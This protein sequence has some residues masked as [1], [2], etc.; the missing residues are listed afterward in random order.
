MHKIYFDDRSFIICGPGETVPENTGAGTVG[1][2]DKD[3]VLD[4]IELFK[5]GED[6]CSFILSSHDPAETYRL[7]CSAFK[8]VNAAGGLVMDNDGKFLLIKRNSVWDL[9]KGHQE[10]GEDIVATAIREVEEETGAEGLVPGRLL[11]ITD[12]C[13]YRNGIC[14][15]KHTWWYLMSCDGPLSPVPQT[16]EGITETVLVS[17]DG[18]EDLMKCTYPSILDVFAAAEGNDETFIH[19]R[20]ILNI[21]DNMQKATI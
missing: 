13:Y 16:E 7:V 5:N 6:S 9:P 3:R 11:C 14:H 19:D 17:K 10:E 4:A 12:H 1:S 21:D 8:E 15:L 20:R 18:L 2:E